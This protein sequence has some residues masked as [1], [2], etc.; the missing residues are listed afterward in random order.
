MTLPGPERSGLA[1]VGVRGTGKTSV[2]RLLAHEVH[3]SFVDTDSE[4]VRLAGGLTISE[5]FARWGE[6]RFRDLEAQALEELTSKPGQIIATGGGIVLRQTNRVL[7]K[8][9][10]FV[11]WLMA[12]PAVLARRLASN[13]RALRERPALTPAGT[14]GEI[15]AILEARTPLYLE[16]ADAAIDTA[17][18]AV[19]EVAAAVRTAW[20]AARPAGGQVP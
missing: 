14:L 15:A 16:V 12:D 17:G 1:L 3:R 8:A 11:A 18:L 13:P 10:G 19:S 2:G 9:Y 20:R 6:P 4:I 7:L 5:I